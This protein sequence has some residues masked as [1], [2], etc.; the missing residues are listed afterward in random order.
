MKD[1]QDPSAANAKS[2]EL[3]HIVADEL[4]V[5]ERKINRII[6]SPKATETSL[7]SR[8][9]SKI[10]KETK[11]A[12][13]G[14]KVKKKKKCSKSNKSLVSDTSVEQKFPDSLLFNKK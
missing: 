12:S 11:E 9:S 13:K 3:Q 7:T 2:Q 8:P 10:K 4:F 1:T 14:Q 5:P 6:Q